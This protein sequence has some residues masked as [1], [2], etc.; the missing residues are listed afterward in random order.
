MSD[1][2]PNTLGSVLLHRALLIICCASPRQTLLPILYERTK[3][4]ENLKTVYFT[5]LSTTVRAIETRGIHPSRIKIS[6]IILLDWSKSSSIAYLAVENAMLMSPTIISSRP[7]I[8]KGRF[9]ALYV[10]R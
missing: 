10:H 9:E 2:M 5:Y 8:I 6:F 1:W 4:L 3:G 7:S